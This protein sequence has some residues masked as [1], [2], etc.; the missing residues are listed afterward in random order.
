VRRLHIYI[1]AITLLQALDCI[2]TYLV[3]S[4]GLGVEA[5]PLW[6]SFTDN[7]YAVMIVGKTLA[8]IVMSI[9]LYW[10]EGRSVKMMSLSAGIVIVMYVM[11]VVNNFR[12]LL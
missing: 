3:L 7:F 6:S 1:I 10:L 12:F 2:S 9:L 5:N 8:I 11:I 4:S